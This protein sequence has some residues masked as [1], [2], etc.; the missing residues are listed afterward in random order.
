MRG[1]FITLEGGE[2]VGKSTN[3]TFIRNSLSASGI[4]LVETREPG[5]TRLGEAL[6]GVLLG[7]EAEGICPEAELL[8]LFAARA[9]HLEKVI[10]PALDAGKWVLCDRFTDASFAYQ[11][12]GRGLAF[13]RIEQL[14]SWVQ[15][16]LRPDLTILLDAPVEVGMARAAARGA[17]DRFE[18]EPQAFFE[19]VREAYKT[20]AAQNSERYAVVDAS[21]ELADVQGQIADVLVG[22]VER[23]VSYV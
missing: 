17:A 1:K 18:R 10:K 2:G 22:L 5:G 8:T 12:G 21:L 11:G 3:L 20:R 9:E 16:D 19:A 23:G 13:E 4:E 15:G 14:E 7:D 6:R